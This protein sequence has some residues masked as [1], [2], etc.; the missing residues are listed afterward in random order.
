M[1]P[2]LSPHPHRVVHHHQRDDDATRERP[3]RESILRPDPGGESGDERA[4]RRREPTARERETGSKF[5]RR[6]VVRE[7]FQHLGDEDARDGG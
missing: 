2:G 4:V 1:K 7:R 3:I 6:D 5:T